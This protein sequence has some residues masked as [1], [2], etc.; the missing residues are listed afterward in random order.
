MV[1]LAG[2]QLQISFWHSWLSFDG[3]TFWLSAT[4][5]ILAQ[6]AILEIVFNR[7]YC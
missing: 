7:S 3:N 6:L 4:D 2:C 1:I 5:F